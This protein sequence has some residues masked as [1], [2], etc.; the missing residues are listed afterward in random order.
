MVA[1]LNSTDEALDEIF[2]SNYATINILDQLKRLPGV[3][4]C[5]AVW[6]AGLWH[7]DLAES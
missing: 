7:A 6:R 1:T 4:G 5:H 3:G 2:L